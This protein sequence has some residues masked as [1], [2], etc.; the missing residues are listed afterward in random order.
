MPEMP[1]APPPFLGTWQN[2]YIFILV[3][4]ALVIASF[5]FF[6]RAVA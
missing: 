4:E 6:T 5:Y 2:V 3:Y 1:D